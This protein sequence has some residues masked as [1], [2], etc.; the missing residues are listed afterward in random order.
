MAIVPDRGCVIYRMR[1]SIL[2]MEDAL[3]ERIITLPNPEESD[4]ILMEV[5]GTSSFS[6]DRL[7]N[8]QK[9][10]TTNVGRSFSSLA[11]PS[12]RPHFNT[13]VRP[14][15]PDPQL[16]S[17]RLHQYTPTQGSEDSLSNTSNRHGS[18]EESLRSGYRSS[19]NRSVPSSSDHGEEDEISLRAKEIES[20]REQLLSTHRNLHGIQNDIPR[21]DK[22]RRHKRA[23]SD[24]VSKDSGSNSIRSKELSSADRAKNGNLTP[25]SR[26]GSLGVE[27]HIDAERLSHTSLPTSVVGSRRGSAVKVDSHGSAARDS[28]NAS[29][30]NSFKQSMR[31]DA[32][33]EAENLSKRRLSIASSAESIHVEDLDLDVDSDDPDGLGVSQQSGTIAGSRKS[34]V[35]ASM[36]PP[37][38]PRSSEVNAGHSI[39]GVEDSNVKS[40]VANE[41]RE[42]DLRMY[43][44]KVSISEPTAKAVE[45]V[46]KSALSK[47]LEQQ[48]TSDNP[49]AADFSYF[50][51]KGDSDPVRLK[52]YIPFSNNS[53]HPLTV[54]VKKEAT[55]EEVIGYSLYEYTNESLEPPIP[56]HLWDVANWNMRIV[57][58][59][60]SIDEDFPALERTR[61]I[62]KFSF[63][64]FAI[65]QAPPDQ[66]RVN[67]ANRQATSRPV[68]TQKQAAINIASTPVTPPR[69]VLLKV[70][71]YS[72]LEVKQTTTIPMQSNMIMSEIFEAICRKRKYDIKNYVLKM[73]DTR[74]DVPLD[75]TLESLK[76]T[77]FCVL[78]RDRGG[79]GDIFLRPPDEV[80]KMDTLIDQ[81]RFISDEYSSMYKQYYV[82]HKMLMGKH[83]RLL[84]IDG[85]HIHLMPAENKRVFDIMKTTSYHC[86]S[87]ISCKQTKKQ[88]PHF[89]LVVKK[90][91]N[92]VT[93]YDLE[94]STSQEAADACA[95][96]AF[97]VQMNQRQTSPV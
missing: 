38:A 27:A 54:V 95:K 92:G 76:V 83:E 75:K 35:A 71:L 77:E 30:A 80:V 44:Q 18:K 12:S 87:I 82:M 25:S 61:R 96:V 79:A 62:L 22:E 69:T 55:V 19:D 46:P 4:Y 5:S 73:A 50:S 67:E 51:G 78:K 6:R 2:R 49:F 40:V 56:E 36:Q 84:T 33:G 53:E 68:I 64:Q 9:A 42:E 31:V 45:D 32:M 47:L 43:F 15:K 72:T 90:G 91:N 52:I 85:D 74:T 88:S 23:T 24:L 94:S 29:L 13:V 65:C 81:P 11:D 60:G 20:L 7:K 66:V 70:H 63:D 37:T 8:T 59:D 34:A 58:D 41:A 26:L 57:E 89:K 14:R 97:I 10:A 93:T 3:V 21:K 1:Q 86:S 28:E 39:H 48:N 17:D 16:L